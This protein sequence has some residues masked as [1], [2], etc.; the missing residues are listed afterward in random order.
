MIKLVFFLQ[1]DQQIYLCVLYLDI[2]GLFLYEGSRGEPQQCIRGAGNNQ[3]A[4]AAGSL[5]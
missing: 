3:R 2:I 4:W 5:P 1:I